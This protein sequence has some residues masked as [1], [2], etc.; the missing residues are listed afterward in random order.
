MAIT[1]ET[2]VVYIEAINKGFNN[3]IKSVQKNLAGMHAITTR[4]Q[5]QFSDM[6]TATG[7][8]NNRMQGMNTTLGRITA[9]TRKATA[10]FRGFRM[11]MLGVMFFG[12]AISRM[13]GNMLRPA[14]ELFGLFE[15]WTT[16]LQVVFLPIMALLVPLLFK[17]ME[18][19]IQLPEGVKLGIGA[20]A[21]F[22]LILGKI[23]FTIGMLSLGLGSLFGTSF[24][25][26]IG[27]AINGLVT[28]FSTFI[29]IGVI[30]AAIVLAVFIGFFAA[31]I[32]NFGRIRDFVK[33]IWEGI[34]N[35]FVGSMNIMV[36]LIKIIVGIFTLN[37]DKIKEG[38]KQMWTG[39]KGTALGLVQVIVGIVTTLGLSIFRVVVAIINTAIRLI[40]MIPGV[41]L[42]T[43]STR[44]T[45][46]FEKDISKAGSNIVI[47]QTI[48]STADNKESWDRLIRENNSSMVDEVKRLTQG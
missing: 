27:L 2:I 1:R 24:F 36:G 45:R 48:N 38:W 4:N 43:I 17:F 33:L 37:F 9:H 31:L 28:L 11:E 25:A 39:M 10:G 26:N 12:M 40:N 3:V 21:I 29:S 5:E 6:Q 41:E 30:T 47:N 35:Q 42:S 32:T 7:G 23:L 16:T 13:F 15:I 22:G 34:K 18:F 14:A 20:I 19:F 8:L 44:K 46:G